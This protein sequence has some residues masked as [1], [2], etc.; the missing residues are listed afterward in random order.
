LQTGGVS[1]ELLKI[2]IA[3][4]NGSPRTVEFQPHGTIFD[5]ANSS[6]RE[7]QARRLPALASSIQRRNDF[8]NN[9]VAIVPRS[10]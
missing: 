10:E 3:N 5:E 8:A 4:G 1:A 9:C 7:H 6:P 2:R